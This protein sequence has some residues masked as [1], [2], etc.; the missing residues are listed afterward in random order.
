MMMLKKMKTKSYLYFSTFIVCIFPI[1]ILILSVQYTKTP[2]LT[3]ILTELNNSLND[4]PLSE[5]QYI[6]NC[7]EN[8]FVQTLYKVPESFPGCSCVN[9]S[10]YK[11]KQANKS[12]VS[13]GKCKK[14]YTLN[15]CISINSYPSVELNKWH[16]NEFCAKRYN[17]TLG[18]KLFFKDSVGKNDNCKKGYK[19]CGKLD[20]ME[21]YLCIPE[22]ESCPINDI[23]ISSI[24]NDSF[25]DAYKIYE[26]GDKYLYYSNKI[27]DNPIV[28]KLK[29]TEGKLC[30]GMPYFHT[31]YPQFILDSNFELYGCRFKIS[32]SLYDESIDKLDY[33]T[34]EELFNDNNFSMFSRYNYSCEY[35]YYSLNAKLFLYP[36]RYIG[37]DKKCL[38]EHNLDI[39]NKLFE[40]DTINNINSNLLLN[41]HLHN[42]LIWISIAAIDFYFMTC[43]FINIDEE[44]NLKNFYIW[45]LITVPFYLSMTIISI[46]GLIAM[47]SI[48]TY[49]YCND[50]YTNSKL[51]LFNDVKDSFLCNT[52]FIFIIVNGE[53]LFT[54]ILYI[55][56]RRKIL[57][58]SNDIINCK[59][60]SQSQAQSQMFGSV[61]S[62]TQHET[63]FISHNTQNE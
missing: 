59:P 40:N 22:N 26:I 47:S 55:F 51:E 30:A 54:I 41:R 6:Q 3:G 60:Q 13:R 31:D 19:K 37:F 12:L 32:N 28:T 8:Q 35:P 14:N 56:K 17:S 48:K 15:G 21:N 61:N 18:Y 7:S 46:I 27:Y 16:S 49:P 23:F 9:I 57:R 39:D 58:N 11:F 33:M 52:L 38:K 45:C 25:N 43:F 34:K 42:I 36:K 1:I 2:Y 62:I 29:T 20:N 53:L 10:Y 5:L 63:P 24:K 4:F 50:D 44:N